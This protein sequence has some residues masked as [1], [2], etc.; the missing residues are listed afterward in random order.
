VSKIFVESLK[1][2][3]LSGCVIFFL[4]YRPEY[5]C[6]NNSVKVGNEDVIDVLTSED[7]ENMPL[8]SWMLFCM[9]VLSDLFS[10]KTLLSIK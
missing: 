6:T 5:F 1:F 4:L 8:E 7:M 9:S 2:V 3:F 10:T